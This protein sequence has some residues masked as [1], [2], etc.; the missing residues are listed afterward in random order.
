MPGLDFSKVSMTELSTSV[1]LA[2]AKTRIGFSARSGWESKIR[3]VIRVDVV[4]ILGNGRLFFNNG[5]RKSF[6]FLQGW[7]LKRQDLEKEDRCRASPPA[8]PF[9]SD[10]YLPL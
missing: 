1:K 5:L 9:A 10:S 2:A 4:L 7:Y 3:A 8:I 6:S